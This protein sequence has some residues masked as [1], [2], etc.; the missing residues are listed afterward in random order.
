MQAAL[1]AAKQEEIRAREAREVQEALAQAIKQHAQATEVMTQW[2]LANK[3]FSGKDSDWGRIETWKDAEAHDA[4]EGREGAVT[5]LNE[6]LK[7]RQN[8][9]TAYP[10]AEVKVSLYAAEREV[11]R[12]YDASLDAAGPSHDKAKNWHDF[13]TGMRDG[14]TKANDFFSEHEIHTQDDVNT[15]DARMSPERGASAYLKSAKYGQKLYDRHGRPARTRAAAVEDAFGAAQWEVVRI[16]E[17]IGSLN[18]GSVQPHLASAVSRHDMAVA[19]SGKWQRLNELLNGQRIRTW[20]DVGKLDKVMAPIGPSVYIQNAQ[21]QQEI[22]NR[23]YL[24]PHASSQ[25]SVATASWDSVRHYP[26]R[27]STAESS[28]QESHPS[29]R[30]PQART[31]SP[32]RGKR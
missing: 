22:Y 2:R 6:A 28:H 23:D 7:Q 20:A 11:A 17:V 12:A 21:H 14:W 8:Y 32:A 10:G 24:G 30:D 5:R 19:V 18:P 16:E 15:N 4:A 26:A 29:S 31:P 25:Q 3:V 9:Y 1:D 27:Q 13:A